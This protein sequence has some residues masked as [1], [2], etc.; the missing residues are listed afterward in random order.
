M[1]STEDPVARYCRLSE[2]SL[3]VDDEV[4]YEALCNELDSLWASLS[5]EDKVRCKDLILGHKP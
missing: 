2:R 5:P 3:F 4:A 1:D